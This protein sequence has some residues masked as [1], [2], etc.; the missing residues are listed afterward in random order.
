MLNIHASVMRFRDFLIASMPIAEDVFR[1]DTNDLLADWLQA[2]WEILVE[3]GTGKYISHYGD[4]AD[5]NGRSSRVWLPEICPTH[6]VA[7]RNIAS[8]NLHSF[9]KF[10][11]WDGALYSEAI[12]LDHILCCYE[13]LTIAALSETEF[14]LVEL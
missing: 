9:T 11:C 10:I 13:P 3:A 5:C 8:G 12:P 14:V 4:G 6:R 1:G 7:R 2:N